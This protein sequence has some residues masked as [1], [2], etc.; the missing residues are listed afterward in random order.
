MLLPARHNKLKLEWVGPYRVVRKVTAV[1]YE[2]QT[3]G[4]RQGK[5]TYHA[6]LLKKWHP[7]EG[8]SEVVC[9]ALDPEGRAI[10]CNVSKDATLEA[11]LFSSRISLAA[12]HPSQCGQLGLSGLGRLISHWLTHTLG[13]RWSPSSRRSL[14]CWSPTPTG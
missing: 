11:S 13:Y 10:H 14:L 4:N 9:L 2:L 6:N 12:L 7:A 5:K 3:P 1:D 8:G